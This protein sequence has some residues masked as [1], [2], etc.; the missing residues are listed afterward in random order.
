MKTKKLVVFKLPGKVIVAINPSSLI[1]PINVTF[2]PLFPGLRAIAIT[3]I[4]F[5][6]SI[7]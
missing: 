1:A 5:S 3:P 4:C 6:D 7:M 2:L